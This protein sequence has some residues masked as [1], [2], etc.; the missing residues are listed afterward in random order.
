MPTDI[1]REA[2]KHLIIVHTIIIAELLY[3]E[4]AEN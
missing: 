3:I 2:N 4:R 1:R